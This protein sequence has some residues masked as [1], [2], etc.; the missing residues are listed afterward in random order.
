[1]A[2]GGRSGILAARGSLPPTD[3]AG[4]IRRD[5]SPAQA[6][7]RDLGIR[8]GTGEAG[9]LD[10]ITDV[11][12]VRVGHRTLIRGA[13]GAPDAVR[14]GVTAIFPHEGEPW[15]ERVYAGTHILNG[16]GEL[17]GI[18]QI[19]EWGVL[20][21]PIVLTSSLRSARPTTPPCGGSPAATGGRRGGHAGGQRVRRLV[22]ERRAVVPAV[23][24]G[25]RGGALRRR[26]RARGRG[27]RRRRHRHAVLRLQGRDRHGVAALPADAGGFTV[28]VLVLTNF[29]DREFLQIDGVPVGEAITD[30][31]PTHHQDGSC[32][33]VVATDAPLLPHQ[34][35]RLAQ[36]GGMGLA[37]TG[38]YASNGCGE[39]MIAFST[40]NRLSYG[41]AVA[42]VRAVAD[43]PG[44]EPWLLSRVFDATVEATQEAVVNALL[45]A[46]TTTGKDGWTLHAMPVDRM[47]ELMAA[48]GR[49]HR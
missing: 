40:A 36:R 5:G 18:N 45:A 11:A 33:V 34:L 44:E 49:L 47:L 31:M 24:R 20:M 14:T 23:R 46:E 29:G 3:L 35:R 1:M 27:L 26:L 15:Q 43:G 13:D 9:P 38:S 25:R 30:L 6:R 48:A 16:Y 12:G 19:T 17:I 22:A 7:A 8:I 10:A 42:D 41:G 2:M 32:V 21:R 39:Q 37:A 4:S 28:G